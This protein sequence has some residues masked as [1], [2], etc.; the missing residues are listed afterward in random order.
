[1]KYLIL[2]ATILA[3]SA[4]LASP[5]VPGSADYDLLSPYKDWITAQSTPQGGLCCSLAD[6]RVA[7]YRITGN[8]IEAFIAAKDERGYNKFPGAP[9]AYLEVPN[10][11]IKRTENPTGQAIAC[12]AVGHS[13]NL[14]FYCFFLPEMG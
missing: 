1:M 13:E 4:A 3:S 5:P 2:A 10:E 9:N 14:G 8:K 11:V 7:P 6:C 12:W